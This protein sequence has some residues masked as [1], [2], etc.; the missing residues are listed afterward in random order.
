MFT[1]TKDRHQGT[2]DTAAHL[3]MDT[4]QYTLPKLFFCTGALIL[5]FAMAPSVAKAIAPRSMLKALHKAK[6]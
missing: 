6:T 2:F 1:L 4:L 3:F 5:G